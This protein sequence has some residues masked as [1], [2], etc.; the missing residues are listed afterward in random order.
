MNLFWYVIFGLVCFCIGVIVGE[1]VND[2]PK[3]INWDQDC[4]D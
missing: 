2:R 1:L 4:W 3:E